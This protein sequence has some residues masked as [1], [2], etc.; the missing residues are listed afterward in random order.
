MWTT[1][2]EH[3]RQHVKI[4]EVEFMGDSN[5]VNF[6][7]FEYYRDAGGVVIDPSVYVNKVLEADGLLKCNPL[8]TPGRQRRSVSSTWRFWGQPTIESTG[9]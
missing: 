8:V 5:R 7:G 1:A 3:F 9:E 4:P 2:F 6:L